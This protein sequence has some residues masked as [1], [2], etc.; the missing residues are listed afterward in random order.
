LGGADLTHLSF[1]FPLAVFAR[2]AMRS[3]ALYSLVSSGRPTLVFLRGILARGNKFLP[4]NTAF[5]E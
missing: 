3:A 5:M 4:R 2:R 1:M